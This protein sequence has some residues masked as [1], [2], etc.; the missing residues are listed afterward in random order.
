LT[1]QV[2][3]KTHGNANPKIVHEILLAELKKR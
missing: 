3:K 2:M 1:G